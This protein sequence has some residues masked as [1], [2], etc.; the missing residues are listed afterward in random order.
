MDS[1]EGSADGMVWSE[2]AIDVMCLGP[3]MKGGGMDVLG[4]GRGHA[5]TP[6]RHECECDCA[7]ARGLTWGQ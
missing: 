3:M 5:K 2:E 4:R 7:S 1:R 6:K